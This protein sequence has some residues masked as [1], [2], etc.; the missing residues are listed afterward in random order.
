MMVEVSSVYLEASN[1]EK[2]KRKRAMLLSMIGAESY[3][4]LKSYIAPDLPSGKTYNELKAAII[5]NCAPVTSP[6]AESYKLSMMKQ[7]PSESLTLFMSRIKTCAAKCDYGNTFD[8]MVK[9][10]FIC[11]IRSEKL[12][13]HLRGGAPNPTFFGGVFQPVASFL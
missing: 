9:D 7:E 1:N 11:G 10:K 2:P 13:A 3:S 8:C 4:L 5:R 6:V 12:R